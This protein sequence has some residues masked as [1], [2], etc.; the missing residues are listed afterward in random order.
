[1][2]EFIRDKKFNLYAAIV[3]MV[4]GFVLMVNNTPN[5]AG[6]VFLIIGFTFLVISFPSK[7]K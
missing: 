5:N 2:K 3:M 1:M 6:V 4:I 7:R